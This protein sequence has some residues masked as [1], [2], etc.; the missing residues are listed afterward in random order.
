[1][2]RNQAQLSYYKRRT[3]ML[4]EKPERRVRSVA[5][6][7]FQPTNTLHLLSEYE[8]TTSTSVKGI[9][10]GPSYPTVTG[11]ANHCRLGNEADAAGPGALRHANGA[12]RGGLLACFIGPLDLGYPP[13]LHSRP[14]KRLENPKR[15]EWAGI[16]PL[17]F[18]P[19]AR[20]SA[21]PIGR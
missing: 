7:F 21:I 13:S 10:A 12:H 6:N 17:H 19:V 14:S 20:W 18:C 11:K 15:D 9:A 1:M 3:T 16:R 4:G 5:P 2:P 8:E